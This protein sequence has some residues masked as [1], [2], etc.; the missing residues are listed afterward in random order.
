[1]SLAVRSLCT[2]GKSLI[3]ASRSCD[4]NPNLPVSWNSYLS[5][6]PPLSPTT[7][8]LE[9]GACPP[10]DGLD[11]PAQLMRMSTLEIDQGGVTGPSYQIGNILDI[12]QDVNESSDGE[13]PGGDNCSRLAEHAFSLARDLDTVAPEFS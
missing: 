2:L 10:T 7:L 4:N 13:T 5:S 6:L 1:M 11:V 3:D 12:L 9:D 8:D